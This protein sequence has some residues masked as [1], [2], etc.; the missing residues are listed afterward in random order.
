MHAR[1]TRAVLAATGMLTAGA[2]LGFAPAAQAQQQPAP[3]TSSGMS[4]APL[5][6]GT[7]LGRAQAWVDAGVPYDQTSCDNVD[8]AGMYRQ[9]CSGFVSM[10]W[11]LSSSLVTTGF[12][13]A[14]DGSDARFQTVS[15]TGLAPGDALVYDSSAN[16][17][18]GHHHIVLFTGWGSSDAGQH[19]YA[20][21]AEEAYPGTAARNDLNVDL[22]AGNDA[23]VGYSAYT[24]IHY[25]GLVNQPGSGFEVALAGAGTNYLW[26]R[27]SDGSNV[28]TKQGLA[29]G[30]SPA[31]T[32]MPTGGYE[33]AFHAAGNDDLYTVDPNGSITQWHLGM[34]PGTSPAITALPTGGWVVAFHAK[35]DALYTAF[36]DG[37]NHP[38]GTSTVEPGSSPAITTLTGGGY[39]IAYQGKGDQD[40][41]STGTTGTHRFG[42]GI[43]PGTNPAITSQ[44][45]NGW[46]ATFHAKGDE[47]YTAYSDYTNRTWGLSLDT[48]TSPAITTLT[49]GGYQIAISGKGTQDLWT[50]GTLGSHA[51]NLGISPG[52]SPTITNQPN[53]G[54]AAAFH[55][56]DGDLYTITNTNQQAK[57]NLSLADN[58]SPSIA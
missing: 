19:R 28:N 27:T 8:A 51:N 56:K 12:N 24:P 22:V 26:T 31:I 25:T 52:T 44:P 54:W 39:Q 11:A 43:D 37:S 4:G 42:L 16:L 38:V 30:T 50:T 58:T 13:P 2:M 47:L 10:A 20:N 1:R 6:A 17:N 15:R 36:S 57:P 53:N 48:G 49:G 23:V 5:S 14:Y 34:A 21:L 41:W 55:A 33:L 18:A 9:D 29:A 7:A 40:L 45:N 3:C 46:V 35:G 32:R